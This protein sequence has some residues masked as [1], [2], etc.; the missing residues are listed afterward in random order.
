MDAEGSNNNSKLL[1]SVY[2]VPVIN[3]LYRLLYVII[4]NPYVE[5]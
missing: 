5:G 4:T 3:V 1:S 2:H